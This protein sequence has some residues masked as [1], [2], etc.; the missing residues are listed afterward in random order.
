M[1]WQVK[2]TETTE[3]IRSY[4]NNAD[5]RLELIQYL[6]MCGEWERALKQIGQFQKIFARQDEK[7]MMYLLNHVEAELRR[8]GVFRTDY[9]PLT[10]VQDAV[11]DV[12]LEKQ[13]SLLAFIQEQDEHRLSEI[14]EQ[15]A[16]STPDAAVTVSY[17]T[18]SESNTDAEEAWLIDGDI[19]TAFV[20]ELFI[21]GRYYWQPWHNFS[22]IQLSQPKA[23]LDT[24]WRSAEITL[25]NK[26]CFQAS[27]PARYGFLPD[28]AHKGSL[29]SCTETVWNPLIVEG[30]YVGCGQKILYGNQGE[31]PVL[32]IQSLTFS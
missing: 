4:P 18:A 28:T 27:I 8:A 3:R 24:I 17:A 5:L 13:L 11:S 23:L 19:R 21:D 30:L 16:N 2:L 25:R 15:L 29:L 12:I 22:S 14:Y 20:C 1:D 31:Y 6:C 9:K 26:T 7:L 10:L 32:D